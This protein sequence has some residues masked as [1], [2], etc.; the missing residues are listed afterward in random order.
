MD[1]IKGEKMRQSISRDLVKYLEKD[2][3]TYTDIQNFAYAHNK[4]KR[5]PKAPSGYWCTS[6]NKLIS[7]KAIIKFP[8]LKR[9]FSIPGTSE[10]K[11]IYDYEKYYKP[12]IKSNYFLH[13]IIRKY[14]L[15]NDMEQDYI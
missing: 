5:F 11:T 13:P 1:F 7:V 15:E 3:L 14:I 2:V 12:V 9:Y 4:N 6:I 8:P 10:N